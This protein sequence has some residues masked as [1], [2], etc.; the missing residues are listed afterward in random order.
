[1]KIKTLSVYFFK[2]LF[3]KRVWSVLFELD[4]VS[5]SNFVKFQFQRIN[6]LSQKLTKRP[7]Q[8][9]NFLHEEKVIFFWK[10]ISLCTIN[11]LCLV[12]EIHAS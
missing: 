9:Q 3:I 7:Q 10:I 5:I 2:C 12:I 11:N 1:M 8:M 4:E 6:I